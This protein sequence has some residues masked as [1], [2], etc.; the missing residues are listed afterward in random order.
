MAG[1]LVQIVEKVLSQWRWLTFPFVN[2]SGASHRRQHEPSGWRAECELH[3]KR[4][5]VQLPDGLVS[6]LRRVGEALGVPFRPSRS[7]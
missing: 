3:N 7:H 6:D 2:G 5:G 1:S 4:A